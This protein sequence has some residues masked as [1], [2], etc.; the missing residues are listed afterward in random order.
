MKQ[1]LRTISGETVHRESTNAV[2]FISQQPFWINA[3]T[4]LCFLSIQHEIDTGP[5]LKTAFSTG[6][7]VFVP[8]T[9]NDRLQFFQIQNAQGPWHCG[10]YTIREPKIDQASDMLNMT[11]FPAL[12]L[13]PGLAFDRRGNRLGRGKGCYDRFC[14]ELTEQGSVYRTVGLCFSSQIVDHVPT[15]TYDIKMDTI[16][17]GNFVL[18]V[19]EQPDIS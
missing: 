10:A 7:Q 1:H 19:T 11:N 9:I 13:V 3:K 2:F 12:I 6:K 15:E 4:V 17:T 14:A 8:K 18:I 5:L 16:V